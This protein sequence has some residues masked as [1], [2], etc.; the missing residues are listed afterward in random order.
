MPTNLSQGTGVVGLLLSPSQQWAGEGGESP[1]PHDTHKKA[2]E[3]GGAGG[4]GKAVLVEGQ[5]L[6]TV[7]EAGTSH[8]PGKL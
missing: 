6:A 2:G 1:C 3:D 4:A 7:P 8:E 5:S